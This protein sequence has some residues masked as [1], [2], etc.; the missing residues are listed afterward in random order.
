MPWASLTRADRKLSTL[1]F[2]T[3]AFGAGDVADNPSDLTGIIL[4]QFGQ[5]VIKLVFGRTGYSDGYC[6]DNSDDFGKNEKYGIQ[7]SFSLFGGS[8]DFVRIPGY[9][10]RRCSVD[11]VN[12][13]ILNRA[14]TVV[15]PILHELGVSQ[16]RQ[17]GDGFNQVR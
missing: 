6:D 16:D 8:G 3:P 1:L 10:A 17:P 2:F 9:D 13:V 7:L 5:L 4:R 15:N 12:P 14:G 11:L